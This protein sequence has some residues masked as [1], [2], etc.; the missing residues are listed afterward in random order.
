MT[1]DEIVQR[2]DEIT[3]GLDD[4]FQFH[5]TKCGKCC[6]DREDILLTARDIYKISA[7]LKITPM[8]IFKTYCESY[9]GE[10]SRM[11]IV[12][13][14]PQGNAKRCVF[15]KNRKCIVHA[16]KPSVCALYPLGRFM[17]INNDSF[18]EG[19]LGD[20]TVQ[21]LLQDDVMCGDKS[22]THKVR[23]WIAGFDIP[24]EDAAFIAWN[25]AL[26]KILPRVK[27]LEANLG[28][29]SQ[30]LLWNSIL[31]GLYLNYDTN[32]EYLPQLTENVENLSS[33][34]D[35]T[36]KAVEDARHAQDG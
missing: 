7:Y 4:T 32:R 20:A 27:A 34:L 1:K 17:K 13:L 35:R 28:P 25:N 5:C 12:R 16:A 3:M 15:L 10:N 9:I 8:E 31:V 19:S 23:E 24:V 30:M 2:I 36:E 29:L 14:K 21:Y 26:A 33:L 11:P 6:I 22:E 18:N